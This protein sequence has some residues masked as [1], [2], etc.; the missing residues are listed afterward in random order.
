MTDGL[1]LL[2]AVVV[3]AVFV[4]IQAAAM[5]SLGEGHER[6]ASSDMS[7]IVTRAGLWSLI[8][9]WTFFI[10]SGG[11]GGGAGILPAWFVLGSNIGW[12]LVLNDP[13]ARRSWFSPIDGLPPA[14]LS[15]ACSVS[16]Y[17]IS[18]VRARSRAESQRNA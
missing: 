2:Y 18:A 5:Y 1:P 13:S 14:W 11:H 3:S 8:L 7:A 9:S 4:G 10:S 16:A 6:R 17:V 12:Y 15:I